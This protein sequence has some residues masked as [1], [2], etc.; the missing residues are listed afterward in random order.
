[1]AMRFYSLYYVL[2]LIAIATLRLPTLMP[3]I[4]LLGSMPAP[5]NPQLT[6]MHVLDMIAVHC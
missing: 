2:E 6:L 5:L 1:M 3:P 4:N